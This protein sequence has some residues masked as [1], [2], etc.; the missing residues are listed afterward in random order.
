MLQIDMNKKLNYISIGIIGY[1]LFTGVIY[2][3]SLIYTLA[4]TL[5]LLINIYSFHGNFFK[6][7]E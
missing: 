2:V 1:C 7:F 5:G 4:A 3:N 6:T